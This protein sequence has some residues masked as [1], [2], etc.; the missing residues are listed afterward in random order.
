[1]KIIIKKV[2]ISLSHFFKLIIIS[3]RI[4]I[5]QLNKIAT[6]HFEDDE[7]LRLRYAGQPGL[8]RD[9]FFLLGLISSLDFVYLQL[10][11]ISLLL[12]SFATLG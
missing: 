9:F 4:D 10:A 5:K 2:I 12:L 6:G 1:M 8:L 7:I 11:Y 3:Y